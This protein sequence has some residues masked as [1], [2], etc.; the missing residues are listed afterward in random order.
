MEKTR[1]I[2]VEDDFIIQDELKVTLEEIG[3][4]VVET[5]S[6]ADEAIEKA[7]LFRPDLILMDIHLDH[8]TDGIEAA[9]IIRERFDI[10]VVFITAYTDGERIERAKLTHPYGCHSPAIPAIAGA[11]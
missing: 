2:I 10:P 11:H 5:A 1:I 4:Q 8:D 9:A 6:V 7:G 3:Y